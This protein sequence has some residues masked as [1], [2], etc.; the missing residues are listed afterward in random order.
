MIMTT[1][2]FVVAGSAFLVTTLAAESLQEQDK[3]IA[4]CAF[5]EILSKRNFGLAEQL[6]DRISSTTESIAIQ[7]WRKTRRR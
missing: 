4:K 5:E 7:L 3:A 6:Y 1:V 2:T